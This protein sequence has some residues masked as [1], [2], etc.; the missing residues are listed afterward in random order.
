VSQS[1]V[2]DHLDLTDSNTL[3]S[4]L[5]ESTEYRV[6]RRFGGKDRYTDDDGTEKRIGLI[7][8]VE[9]TG[10]RYGADRIIEL[11]LLPF[12][13]SRDGRIFAVHKA[14]SQFEDPGMQIPREVVE[15]TGITDEVV[16]NQRIDDGTV[17]SLVSSASLVIAHNSEFDRRFAE[18]RFSVFESVPWAC[19][20]TQVPWRQEGIES[21]KLEY[22]AYRF[23]F[24]YSEHRAEADCRAVLHLLAHKLPKSGRSAMQVMLER[25]RRKTIRLWA[26][27]SP[28]ELK[29]VLKSRGYL[30][31]G[32]GAKYRAWYTD[33]DEA[34]IELEREFLW[35]DIYG[36][37]VDL[38]FA[39]LDCY[40]RFS[41]R[42]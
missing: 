28:Y 5:A 35:G 8:D 2:L 10:T 11:G 26:V 23:G 18:A 30:W 12:E 6:I 32:E 22:L 39:V 16:R 31:A 1:Q 29:G 37:R 36:R 4:A 19:S 17:E 7:L 27:N 24:F 40:R 25:A 33:V 9:T 15:L 14:I 42:L 3:A 41:G 38:P 21:A 20:C 13:F 34:E